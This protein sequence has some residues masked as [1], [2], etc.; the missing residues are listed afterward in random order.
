MVFDGMEFGGTCRLG[1]EALGAFRQPPDPLTLPSPT[2]G[3]GARSGFGLAR[4]C[5][6]MS[7]QICE[8]SAYRYQTQT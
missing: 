5:S 3:M 7:V 8:R 6:N 4:S 1:I 2:I